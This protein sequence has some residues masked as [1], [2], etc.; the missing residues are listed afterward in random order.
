[1]NYSW[2]PKPKKRE[3][4]SK[5]GFLRNSDYLKLIRDVNFFL[6]PKQVS[7]S[8]QMQRMYEVRR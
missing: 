8:N 1:M 5:I 3:P 2:Q 4:F 6:L 7:A